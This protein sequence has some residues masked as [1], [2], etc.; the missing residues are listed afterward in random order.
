MIFQICIFYFVKVTKVE[1]IAF[2]QY[3]NP[4]FVDIYMIKTRECKTE[5]KICIEVDKGALLRTR[6]DKMFPRPLHANI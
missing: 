4:D 3:Q 2:G 6:C 1:L 5:A